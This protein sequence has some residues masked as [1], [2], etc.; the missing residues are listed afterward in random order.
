MTNFI[1]RLGVLL[2]LDSAEFTRGL[3]K[4]S[5]QLDVFVE[6]AKVTATI[7][8]GAFAAMAYQ[9]MQLAD[10]IVDTAKANDVAVDSVLKLRNALALSGGEAENA[11]KLY[12]SFTAN[13][14]KAAEGSY[15]TQKTFKTLGVSLDDL[16]KMNIDQLFSKTVESLSEMEDPLTR[17][18][19]GMELFGK[20]AK[21][22]DFIELNEQIKTG[23]GVTEAQAKAIEDAAAAYDSLAKAGRD[24]S[25]MLAS[26]LGPSIKATVEYIGGMKNE[27]DITGKVFKTVF[28]TVVV[29][30]SDVAFVIK[31]IVNEMAALFRFAD[32][33]VN[34]NLATAT[35][36]YSAYFK[37]AVQD[38]EELDKFQSRIL[39]AGQDTSVSTST[40]SNKP[41]F[42]DLRDVVVGLS[43]EEKKALQER[44][45][46]A[47]KA[48]LEAEAL[49]KRMQALVMQGFAEEQ[50]AR[51]ESNLLLAEQQTM[52][53]LGDQAQ[54]T[55]QNFAE[56]E[57]TRAQ[58]MLELV[59]AGRKMRGE[60]LQLAQEIKEIEWRRLDARK[61]INEDDKLSREGREAALLRENEL[62][63]KA[64]DLARQRNALA[65]QVREGTTSEG[66]FDAMASAARNAA[67][68]FER[69][70]QAFQSVVGNMEMAI[71]NFVRTGKLSFKDLA[72]SIIQDMIAIQMK[73]AAMKFLGGL[74]GIG[75]GGFVNDK[76]GMELAGSLGFA[77][78][79]DPPVNRAS[80]VGERG[81]ELFVPKTAGTIIP[82]HALSNMSGT[83]NVTNN[84][85]NAI[86]AKSFENR[87]LES[88]N[89]IW[90]GYQYAN[91]QLASNGRRA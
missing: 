70:Q 10:E 53:Q 19:K 56:Q 8:A 36:N 64:L 83:T 33:L 66:F 46:A 43:P 32:D 61:A 71:N 44:E 40:D 7:G 54:R 87:L 62:A 79:G 15:E 82:N 60:D 21:G 68:E 55:R 39:G 50:R 63:E 73:A 23:A 49:K 51:E 45:A 27:F 13:I 29:V 75:G 41:A 85:I 81:P 80:I 12:S 1:G 84:Y 72:R 37:K 74:F 77:N 91:K 42:G 17:N 25:V 86:D 76:G 22:V 4:A 38:R 57:I 89:T 88:S 59:H 52:L 5:K 14:D 90:A 9:A 11:G 58:E 28:Q 65:K 3:E 2:G 30:G 16:R 47:K 78:G 6:K 67:T 31:S 18:A 34:K 35:A 26:E 20:A 69:G 24:F 48:A